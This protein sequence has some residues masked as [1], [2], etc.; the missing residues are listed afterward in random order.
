[1]VALAR[2]YPHGFIS[3]FIVV[4]FGPAL[5]LT[6]LFHELAKAWVT[7]MY[8]GTVP[9]IVLWPLG[10]LTVFG[11]VGGGASTEL[12]VAFAGPFVHLPI[13][14]ILAG[15]YALLTNGD[16]SDFAVSSNLT[17]ER[18]LTGFSI[19]IVQQLFK[20]NVLIIMSNLIIPAFPLDG[21][22]IVGALL[23]MCGMSLSSAAT[24]TASAG[25]I[26]SL[27]AFAYGFYLFFIFGSFGAMFELVVGIYLVYSS[28]NQ[29]IRS[30]SK[31]LSTDLIFGGP[32]YQ[33]RGKRGSVNRAS[34]EDSSNNFE[35]AEGRELDVV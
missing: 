12:K 15:I 11:P 9:S 16:M 4:L 1:M 3:A 29:L 7:K 32:C 33:K 34:E 14:L 25:I 17:I 19:G 30:V 2:D 13:I 6:T 20:L 28:T 23:M 27:A 31:T 10:G 8:G 35:S 24:V 22:R 18:S 26:M 5:I 21:G